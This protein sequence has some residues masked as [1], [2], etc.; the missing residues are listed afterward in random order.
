M[1]ARRVRRSHAASKDAALA[2]RRSA[3]RY[4][5]TAQPVSVP[6][7]LRVP[8]AGT[9]CRPEPGP[10]DIEF[11]VE[12]CGICHSDLHQIKDEWGGSTVRAA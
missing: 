6:T 7:V 9:A 10:N 1:R 3:A 2:A 4:R 12:F 8:L 5:T 11:N